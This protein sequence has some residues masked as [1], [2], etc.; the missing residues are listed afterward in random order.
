MRFTRKSGRDNIRIVDP[1]AHG[2]G[3]LYP[4]KDSPKDWDKDTPQRIYEMWDY[5]VRGA[6]NLSGF[7]RE[8]LYS[9]IGSWN[10]CETEFL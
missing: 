6:L 7:D 5:I 8:K 1:K 2:V 9:Q 10:T 4:P 3:F